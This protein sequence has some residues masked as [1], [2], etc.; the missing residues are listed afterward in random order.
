MKTQKTQ[1]VPIIDIMSDLIRSYLKSDCQNSIKRSHHLTKY[2]HTVSK[3]IIK[4]I[5][6]AL[7]YFSENF[8]VTSKTHPEIKTMGELIK[9][10]EDFVVAFRKQSQ[11]FLG[12][13][14]SFDSTVKKYK[15]QLDAVLIDFL[16]F[17]GGS[18]GMDMGY[19]SHWLWAK[20]ITH[21]YHNE[22]PCH[23]KLDDNGYCPNCEFYPS[24]AGKTLK[25]FCSNCRC[26]KPSRKDSKPL[27]EQDIILV[28][29]EFICPNCN[30]RHQV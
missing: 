18:Y 29:P 3:E 8:F 26:G 14:S 1:A 10:I 12:Y 17:S 27:Q 25:F 6:F 11:D 16:N 28:G 20:P 13:L 21:S 15:I 19:A 4:L 5:L 23:E 9:K 24:A 22:L 2:R 7:L 30:R